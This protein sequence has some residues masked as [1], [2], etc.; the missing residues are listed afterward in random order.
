MSSTSVSTGSGSTSSS[1][2]DGGSMMGSGGAS[3][4]STSG[5]GASGGTGGSGGGGNGKS[6]VKF[7]AIGDQGKGNQGQYDV[8]A[9]MA[10]K[11]AADGCDFIQLLGDNIYDS[12][13]SS[14]SDPLWQSHFE[15]PYAELDMPFWVVLGNH[16]YGADG[17]GTDFGK[18]KNEIDYTKVSTKW[19][20][21]AAYYKRS[22]KHV[23]FFALDT[24]M[25]MFSQANNQKNDVPGWIAGSTAQWKI[26]LGHHPYL[27]NGKHGNAGSYDGLPFIPIANG[28]GVKDLLDNVV[29]GKVDLYLCGHDQSMQWLVPTCGG[30]TNLVISGAGASTSELGGKNQSHFESLDLGFFYVVIEDNVLTGQF[31]NAAGTVLYTGTITK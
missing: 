27:S 15:L 4:S 14:T 1:G 6:V 10:K 25:A 8:A 11:C 24:N 21:P 31:I 17:A 20:L 19:K 9:A 13:V 28:A 3:S 23:D 12:G 18:G 29:C 22:E 30:S 5:S 26:A 16:D 7:A 2:G